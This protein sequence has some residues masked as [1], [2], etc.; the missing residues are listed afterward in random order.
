MVPGTSAFTEQRGWVPVSLPAMT[1]APAYVH[2]GGLGGAGNPGPFRAEG[3]GTG[4]TDMMGTGTHG[5]GHDVGTGVHTGGLGGAGNSGPRRVEGLLGTGHTG[6]H[7]ATML[8]AHGTGHDVGT[9]IAR[10][11]RVERKTGGILH[12]SGS[13]SSSVRLISYSLIHFS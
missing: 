12:R 8:G 1:L 13:S 7:D 10:T 5:T 3:L 4:H 11:H 6:I 9:G 2:T